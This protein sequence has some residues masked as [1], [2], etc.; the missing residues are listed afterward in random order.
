LMLTVVLLSTSTVE[1]LEEE[2]FTPLSWGAGL[3]CSLVTL[4]PLSMMVYAQSVLYPRWW[5]RIWQL[6]S[7]MLIGIGV[8]LS[9]SLAVLGAFWGKDREFIRTP[10]FG[11]GAEGGTWW[12]KVYVDRR[13]WEG[14]LELGLGS[15]SA[16]AIWEMQQHEQYAILPFLILYAA[17]FLVVGALTILHSTGGG[18]PSPS[19]AESG[20]H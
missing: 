14:I 11:I 19:T 13:R 16:W 18:M 9:T 1:P 17:G 7:L 2:L 15:Y 8:A 12:G 4:G 6:P 3:A 5:R 10:K 20:G